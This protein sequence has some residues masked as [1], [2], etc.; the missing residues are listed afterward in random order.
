LINYFAVFKAAYGQNWSRTLN[1]FIFAAGFNAALDILSSDLLQLCF[2]EKD[3]SK[4]MFAS[5]LKFD[6]NNLIEQSEVKGLSGE[7]AKDKIKIKLKA[8]IETQ[9]QEDD[10]KF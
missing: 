1:P 10:F 3:F 8:L 9:H 4:E 7:A 5:L 2:A 6:K